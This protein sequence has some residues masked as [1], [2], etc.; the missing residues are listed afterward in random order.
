MTTVWRLHIDGRTFY[1]TDEPSRADMFAHIRK[2]LAKGR[3]L[4]VIEYCWAR[5]TVSRRAQV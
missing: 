1:V 3:A 5:L 2:E 4:A